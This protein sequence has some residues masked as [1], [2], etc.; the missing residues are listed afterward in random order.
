MKTIKWFSLRDTMKTLRKPHE[1]L[2]FSPYF[3]CI[4]IM[5]PWMEIIKYL[6]DDFIIKVESLGQLRLFILHVKC[7]YI[8]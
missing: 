4:A 8:E 7:L 3:L 6:E 1:N 2:Y 5:V